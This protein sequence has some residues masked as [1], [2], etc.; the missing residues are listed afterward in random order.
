MRLSNAFCMLL[1]HGCVDSE[2]ENSSESKKGKKYICEECAEEMRAT[3]QHSS[4]RVS[5]LQIPGLGTA[6][7]SAS[8]VLGQIPRGLFCLP[9]T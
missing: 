2:G 5:F 8:G 6:W 7:S 3:L 4:L 1:T 9:L